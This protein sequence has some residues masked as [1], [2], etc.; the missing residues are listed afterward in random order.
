MNEEFR[1]LSEL[2]TEG[3]T[4][5]ERENNTKKQRNLVFPTLQFVLRRSFGMHGVKVIIN[6]AIG[7][8]N[9]TDW[10]GQTRGWNLFV[11]AV[12]NQS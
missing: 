10:L 5:R 12:V 11:S 7:S 3:N 8:F 2:Q 6:C 9:S 1:L 4:E